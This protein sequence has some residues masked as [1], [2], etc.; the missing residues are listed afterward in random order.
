M[1]RIRTRATRRPRT[2]LAALL[3]AL[4]GLALTA[5]GPGVDG[6][7]RDPNATDRILRMAYL[8]GEEDPEGRMEAFSGLA[9][10]LSER[11]GRE[12]ELI[13]AVSYAPTIEA[14]RASKIDFMR[15]GG[16]FTY[17]IAHEKAG[18]EAI[19]RV[20][21][22]AGP[23]LYESAIVAWPGSG[24]DTLDDLVAR[25]GE[26]DFAFVDPASTSGH[27]IPRA[28]LEQVGIDPDESFAR[29]IFTMSH[30]NSAMT[31]VSGKVQAGAISWNTYT[32][33]LEAGIIEA[34]DM[35]VLWKSDPIP[36]GPIMVRADLPQT[37]KDGLRD[38]YLALND[39][40]LP[41][42][43]AMKAVYGTEDLRFFPANDADW[44]GLRAIARNVDSFQMLP[45]G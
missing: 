37:L 22:S 19:L 11:L 43:R 39:S 18:A 2:R 6:G 28:Q 15:A 31:I 5:C 16:S 36:T 1:T 33:L 3:G 7:A 45:E 17:M 9:E 44:D 20:G 24:I 21:T 4:L 26:I 42:F 13:Q 34:D 29:T 25:A 32:R 35:V 27:L 14:M 10:Y 40:D 38:A 41:V 12:V 30:T 23:G 8:P